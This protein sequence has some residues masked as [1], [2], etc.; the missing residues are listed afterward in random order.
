MNREQVIKLKVK[1][2]MNREVVTAHVDDLLSNVLSL[3]QKKDFSVIPVVDEDNRF[4]GIISYDSLNRRRS[5]PITAKAS[6]VMTNCPEVQQ[7]DAVIDVAEKMM[8]NELRGIPVLSKKKVVG[9]IT[10]SDIITAF[11]GLKIMKEIKNREIMNDNIPGVSPKDTVAST[12]KILQDINEKNIA[13]VDNSGRMMGVIGL[14]NIVRANYIDNRNHTLNINRKYSKENG[15]EDIEVEALMVTPPI[16][17][18]PDD[19]I[20]KT[21]ELMSRHNISTVFITDE[22]GI[23]KGVVSEYALLE[24]FHSFKPNDGVYVQISGLSD[25]H[26][27]VFE[28]MYSLIE[29]SMKKVSKLLKPKVLTIHVSRYNASEGG[30]QK[31]SLTARL[32]T[33]HEMIYGKAFEWDLF[34]ALDETLEQIENNARKLREKRKERMPRK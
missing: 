20:L 9:I 29:K 3:M 12:R 8:S 1:D 2:V 31:Y 33:E 23:L 34:K 14:K 11:K 5:L 17:L 4:Q 24:L 22:K 27:D 15:A 32:T 10:V 13:V 26:P 16:T 18:T 30:R 25:E 7:N 19:T 28:A 21:A 6:S